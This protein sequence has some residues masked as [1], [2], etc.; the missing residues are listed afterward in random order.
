MTAT[1]WSRDESL[2]KYAQWNISRFFSSVSPCFLS[3]SITWPFF[4]RC[5]SCGDGYNKPR[6]WSHSGSCF[7]P[8]SHRYSENGF[9]PRA[10]ASSK[11]ANDDTLSSS[12]ASA[13]E[14]SPVSSEPKP[15]RRSLVFL[16]VLCVATLGFYTAYWVGRSA[17]GQ[18]AGAERRW[19]PLWWALGS[20]APLL[21]CLMLYD[22][23]LNARGRRMAIIPAEP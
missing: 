16:Y 17:R 11:P 15:D 1:N 2:A 3:C 6:Y 12:P 19:T 22:L 7:V 8:E 18:G 23:C 10:T 4:I 21:C 13:N 9:I 5:Q 14:L 20:V